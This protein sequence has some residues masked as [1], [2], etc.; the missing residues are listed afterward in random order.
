MLWIN[1]T[2]WVDEKED[3]G[4]HAEGRKKMKR[5]TREGED[6]EWERAR[7]IWSSMHYTLAKCIGP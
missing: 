5:K 7:G 1:K 4:S 3:A 2:L 6:Y